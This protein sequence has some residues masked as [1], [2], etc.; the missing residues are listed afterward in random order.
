MNIIKRWLAAAAAACL[1]FTGIPF[2]QIHFSLVVSAEETGSYDVLTY[3]AYD[4]YVEITGYDTAAVSV[5]IPETIDGL[6]V[7][8]IGEMAFAE[9]INLTTLVIPDSVETI[10]PGCFRDC[11]SLTE[12]TLSDTNMNFRMQ[13]DLLYNYAG[14]TIIFALAD[15]TFVFLY[16]NE[17]VIADY[18]FYNHD[19]LSAISLP[20][21]LTEIG[22]MAFADCN[23]IYEIAIPDSVTEIGLGA[24]ISSTAMTSVTLP[25]GITAING[26]VFGVVLH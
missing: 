25:S 5:D 9:C 7:T 10:V 11:T 14:D 2:P 23:G 26:A 4:T 6:P 19:N 17:K 22:E 16:G 15:C 20:Y 8:V 18:A 12:I 1:A 21:G 13:G 24:F 3:T